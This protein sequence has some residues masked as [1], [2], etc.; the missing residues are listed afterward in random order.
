MAH[1]YPDGGTTTQRGIASGFSP[2]AK[3]EMIIA[4]RVVLSA[5]RPVGMLHRF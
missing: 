2:G 5:S 4:S 3:A 1:G